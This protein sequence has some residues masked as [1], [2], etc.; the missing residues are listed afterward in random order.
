MMFARTI[1]LRIGAAQTIFWRNIGGDVFL[2]IMSFEKIGQI[3]M[4]WTIL[5]WNDYTTIL[6]E[7]D[8]T[9]FYIENI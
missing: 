9:I 1:Q 8:I 2:W 5:Q 6:E 7:Y 4:N 3:N